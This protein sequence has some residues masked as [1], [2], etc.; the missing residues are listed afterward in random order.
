MHI[1]INQQN[2]CFI[3]RAMCYCIT[4][5]DRFCTVDYVSFP[6]YH[7]EEFVL[8]CQTENVKYLRLCFYCLTKSNL[9][10]YLWLLI[11]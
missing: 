5:Y 3:M 1:T 9:Y 11:K 10:C 2:I 6:A 7:L 4:L 8:T